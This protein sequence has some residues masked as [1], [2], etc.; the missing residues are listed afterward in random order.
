MAG[1]IRRKPRVPL[2]VDP[3][4]QQIDA[5]LT[6]YTTFNEERLRD[7]PD[8]SL[9]DAERAKATT[10]GANIAERLRADYLLSKKPRP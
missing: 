8:G 2:L 6:A 5:W 10:L 4:L 3:G 9:L 7:W 1:L